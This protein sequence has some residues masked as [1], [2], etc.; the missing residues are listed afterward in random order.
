MSGAF[1]AL[2]ERVGASTATPFRVRFPDG[3]EY[4]NS[5]SPPA[6]ILSVRHERALRRAALYGHVGVLE[7]YF[8]G[9]LDIEGSLPAALAAGM[10][11]HADEATWL[12]R[13][14]NRWH[15]FMH[16]NAN[17]RRANSNA[18]YHYALPP[19]F[20]KLWLDDPYMFYT[21]AYWGEGVKTLEEA[22][23]PRRTMSRAR[24]CS[25]RARRWS[26]SA[27]ASAASSC[28]PPCI[29]A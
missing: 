17:R 8:D 2:I 15:E 23:V 21:C 14:R 20:Y 11:A 3:A 12:V 4:R 27:A 29:T 6:F 7:A 25:S 24:C 5:E 18:E 16:T 19:E 22:S 1:R 13:L 10:E 9:E 26:T 28:T